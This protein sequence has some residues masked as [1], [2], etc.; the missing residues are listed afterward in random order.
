MCQVTVTQA[1]AGRFVNQ[2]TAQSLRCVVVRL[3]GWGRRG[4]ASMGDWN[5]PDSLVQEEGWGRASPKSGCFCDGTYLVAEPSLA[6]AP[7]WCRSPVPAECWLSQPS[8]GLQP[9]TPQSHQGP[10]APAQ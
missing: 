7:A 6:T 10:A 9:W 3:E 4:K 5:N 1:Q 2:G 8:L